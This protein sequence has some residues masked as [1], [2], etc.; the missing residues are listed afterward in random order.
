MGPLPGIVFFIISD[1]G[2]E[3]MMIP[4]LIQFLCLD[5]DFNLFLYF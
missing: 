5:T 2:M 4:F 3:F 1:N